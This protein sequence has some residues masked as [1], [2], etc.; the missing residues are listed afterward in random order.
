M[1]KMIP[2]VAASMLLMACGGGSPT[3]QY[4]VNLDKEPAV[5]KGTNAQCDA[6]TKT[7][8]TVTYTG[9]DAE[10]ILSM[11][12]E[13]DGTTYAELSYVDGSG[14]APSKHV[15]SGKKNGDTY[16]LTDNQSVSDATQ[17]TQQTLVSDLYTL[18]LKK[19][20]NFISGS[21][22]LDHHE[23]C[24]N[25]QNSNACNNSP[26]IDCNYSSNLSGRK[27]PLNGTDAPRAP[28]GGK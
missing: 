19:D 16:A 7:N 21:V 14:R 25:G 3:A 26:T 9:E 23:S 22:T 11:F 20:G 24:T 8:V 2:A 6:A 28:P 10:Q 13:K 4:V 15:F 5:T 1:N 27:L 12:E 17:T 18:N